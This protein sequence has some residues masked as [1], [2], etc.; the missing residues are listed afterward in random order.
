MS[1]VSHTNASSKVS[2]WYKSLDNLL[3]GLDSNYNIIESGPIVQEAGKISTYRAVI[4]GNVICRGT[5]SDRIMIIDG[6]ILKNDEGTFVVYVH[7]G[8]EFKTSKIKASAKTASGSLRVDTQNSK[9]IIQNVSEVGATFETKVV[10]LLVK[11][12]FSDI[13]KR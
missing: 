10:N 4:N 11:T 3:F 1:N 6:S 8:E 5:L 13:P 2:Q 7:D 12:M 9:Y